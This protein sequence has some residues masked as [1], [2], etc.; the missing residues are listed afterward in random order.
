MVILPAEQQVPVHSLKPQAAPGSNL[1]QLTRSEGTP[2]YKADVL[3]PH[4]K[5]YYLLV[6]VRRGGGR[7]WVDTTPYTV[8]D[9]TFYFTVPGQVM[10]KEEAQP[11]WGTSLAFTQEFVALQQNAAWAKLPLLQFP[12][13]GHELALGAVDMVFVEDILTKLEGEYFG[14]AGEWRHRM[15]GAYLEVLLIHLSR[16]YVQPFTSEE[17]TAD[18][19]LQQ[20]RAKIEQGFRELHDVSGYASLLHVSAGH[21]SEV[22]KAHSGKPAIAHIQER[23]VLEARRLLFHTQQSV[24]EIGF[25]LGFGDASYFNRFFKRETGLTPAGYRASR[26][27]MYQ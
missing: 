15:L 14:P 10:V 11:L 27:E 2:A 12:Q 5:D 16:L 23:L 24:K 1:F 25:D 6:F 4:R 20:Y 26:R 22:V 7:N 18:K 17:A 3:L 9:N 21:L 19:L 13:H 8:K